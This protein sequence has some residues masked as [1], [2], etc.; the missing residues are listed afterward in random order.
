MHL[1]QKGMVTCFLLTYGKQL[2]LV[3]SKELPSGF[4]LVV[5]DI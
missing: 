3:L 5:P 1:F 2:F 4:Q